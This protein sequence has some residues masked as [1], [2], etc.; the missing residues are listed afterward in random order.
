MNIIEIMAGAQEL[1]EECSKY[2]E[3]I[4]RLARTELAPFEAQGETWV[5]CDRCHS[6]GQLLRRGFYHADDCPVVEAR[7]LL[8]MAMDEHGNLVEEVSD[9][10]WR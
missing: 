4:E 3:F 10:D 1:A 2:R 8:G 6:S 5:R 7:Q 9:E